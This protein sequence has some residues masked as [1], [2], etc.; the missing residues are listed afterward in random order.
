MRPIFFLAVAL[1]LMP[2]AIAATPDGS[3]TANLTSRDV[4]ITNSTQPEDVSPVR[5]SQDISRENDRC[6]KQFECRLSSVGQFWFG[7]YYD[8]KDGLC[9]CYKGDVSQCSVKK[10]SFSQDD[11]CAYQYE[12]LKR[13]DG[14][15]QFNC[16]YDNS[17]SSCRCFVGQL[18]QCRG[19]KSLVSKSR[20][21]E[22]E[23]QEDAFNASLSGDDG[24][25]NGSFQI[26]G[27]ISIDSSNGTN[28]SGMAGF[29]SS[30]PSSVQIGILAL[31]GIIILVVLFFVFR[32]GFEDDIELA[33]EYHRKAEDLHEQ[34]REEEAHK[35]YKLA[36]ECRAKARDGGL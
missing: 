23:A 20:L 3:S 36:E 34:G 7:C 14:Y 4:N 31:V 33:R 11:W 1:V 22:L 16:Y 13:P 12:C 26:T 18:S 24:L 8:E 28:S 17:S 19:D 35:Y 9:R 2:L 15:Y 29:V 5:I 32:S 27:S 21:L 30:I 6:A 10:S 25:K